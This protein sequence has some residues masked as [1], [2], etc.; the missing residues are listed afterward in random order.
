VAIPP[1]TLVVLAGVAP[2]A[3]VLP[4]LPPF[5]GAVRISGNLHGGPHRPAGLDALAARRI[6]A[7]GGPLVLLADPRE[8]TA[9]DAQL[10]P[11][12]LARADTA[13][14]VIDSALVPAGEPAPRLW[15][16]R[17]LARSGQEP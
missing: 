1:D 5:A 15:P 9:A 8:V 11:L 6:A 14:T 16:L 12:G 7:H 17:R 13:G 3:H 10:L 2:T 4:F